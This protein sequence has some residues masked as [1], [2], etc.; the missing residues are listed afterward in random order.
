[1]ATLEMIRNRAGVL[2]AAII[3]LALLAF[4]LGDMMDSGRSIFSRNQMQ[5]AEIDGESVSIQ[6]FQ[7]QVDQLVEIYKMNSGQTTFDETMMEN[8]REQTWQQLVQEKVLRKEYSNLGL[9]VSSQ[10]VYDMVGGDNPHAIIRQI[11]TNPETGVL[12]KSALIQFLKNMD[13]DPSGNQRTFWLYIE[14]EI[15][16]ERVFS[17]YMTLIRQGLYTTSLQAKYENEQSN[18][19]VD[20]AFVVDRFANI[21]DSSITVSESELKKYYNNHKNEF[22]QKASRDVEFVTYAIEPSPEDVQIAEK[23]INDIKPEFSAATDDKQFVNLNSD[24][25][26]DEK[27]KK[28]EEL[29][30]D[31]GNFMFAAK[32]GDVYGPY[33]E[34]K[35]YKLAKLY[36]IVSSPDSVKARHILIAPTAQTPEAS[37]KA[38]ALADSIKN[39]LTKGGDF[40]ALAQQFSQDRG[41][42]AKGGDL[43]WFREGA[44]VQPFNDACF[45]GRKGDITVVESQFGFHIINILDKGA[46]SKKVQLAILDRAVEP[47]STTYQN[48]YQ[49]AS[50][51]AANNRTAEQFEESVKKENLNKQVASY[52]AEND[53]ALPGIQNGRELVR[54]AYKAEKGDVSQVFEFENLF[55]VAKLSTIREEGI[56]KLSEVKPQIEAMVRR[57]KKA[58]QL[59]AKLKEQMNGVNNI[60]DLASK[61]GFTPV[62]APGLT[63]NAYSVPEAG[64][65]PQLIAAASKGT[66]GKLLGPIKGMNGVYAFQVNNVVE[67]DASGV[68]AAKMRLKT[69]MSS[70]T[71]YEA[72]E[73]LRDLAKVKD[74]RAKFY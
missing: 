40:A 56:A 51:F 59:A 71:N 1:M 52:L 12:N 10:E 19:K 25:P 66:T 16:R 73:A 47:S 43:G 6:D 46:E 17:K 34:N 5:V 69:V 23:W 36:K 61:T 32:V 68:E 50:S 2:V 55:V 64:I 24:V 29:N 65:E 60:T 41:S 8:I 48:V 4:I 70:R 18:K 37:A 9:G 53:K 3:G 57:E 30:P 62:E 39:V 28:K 72:F 42:I 35:S 15:M 45:N 74:M 7:A 26:F 49:K 33:F 31:L 58:E 14:S 11:F 13:Q 20:I 38:K 21:A 22:D 27:S 54:W 63:F 44:M 67:A